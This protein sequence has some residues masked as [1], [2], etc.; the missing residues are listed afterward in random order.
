MVQG[1]VL[2]GLGVRV[3]GSRVLGLRSLGFTGA[4][5]QHFCLACV[6]KVRPLYLNV[7]SRGKAGIGMRSKEHC[8]S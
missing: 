2:K 7:A 3:K 4:Y 8:V 1:L 6:M 5:T